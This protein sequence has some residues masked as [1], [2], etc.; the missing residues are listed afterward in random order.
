MAA[1]SANSKRSWGSSHFAAAQFDDWFCDWIKTFLCV[2]VRGCVCVRVRIYIYIII[3]VGGL[4]PSEKDLSAGIM[5]PNILKNKL[6][7]R[8]TPHVNFFQQAAKE[9]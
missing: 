9:R 7:D 3:L 8:M 5:I 1:F 4:N 6:K 2:C